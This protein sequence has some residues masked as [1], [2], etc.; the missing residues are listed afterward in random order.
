MKCF[1]HALKFLTQGMHGWFRLH[2]IP[3]HRIKADT[4]NVIVDFSPNNYFSHKFCTIQCQLVIIVMSSFKYNAILSVLAKQKDGSPQA[5]SM[6]LFLYLNGYWTST[7]P[8]LV[9][10]SE[11]IHLVMKTDMEK[12]VWKIPH[13][14]NAI[15]V[16]NYK[17]HP[18]CDRIP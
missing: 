3:Q 17:W 14:Q 5:S 12:R 7:R 2:V 15:C 8:K 4:F 13:S 16:H 18:I 11:K 1:I 10:L 9:S 6:M